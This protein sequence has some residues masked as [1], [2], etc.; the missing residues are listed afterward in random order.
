MT[1]ASSVVH[2]VLGRRAE[3]VDEPIIEYIVNILADEDFDFGDDGEGAFDALG[4]LLVGAGCVN[5]FAECRS[6]C[7]IISEKFGKHGLVK[8]KPTVRSLSAPVRMDDGMDTKVAPKKKVEVID[9]PL[10]T[11]RDRAKIKK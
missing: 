11:E 10:L 1:V 2:E 9:G 5:A 6:V 7:S 8:A 4:E 3:D